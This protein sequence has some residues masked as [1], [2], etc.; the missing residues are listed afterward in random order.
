MYNNVIQP[1]APQPIAAPQP[2]VNQVMAA[3]NGP[4]VGYAQAGV[5]TQQPIAPKPVQ[6]FVA[7]SQLPPGVVQPSPVLF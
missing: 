6:Q 2:I 7:A 5:Q 1:V 4:M 3:A